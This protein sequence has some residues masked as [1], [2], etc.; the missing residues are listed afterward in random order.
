MVVRMTDNPGLVIEGYASVFG[1]RDL[2][3]DVVVRGA[4]TDALARQGAA[5]VRMLYQHDTAEPVGVWRMAFQDAHGLYVRGELFEDTPKGRLAGRLVRMGALDG[6]S[7]G[8]RT[9]SARRDETGRLRLLTDIDLWEV[10]LVTFPMLPSA[11]IVRADGVPLGSP[12]R[13]QP[14]QRAPY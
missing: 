9:R 12:R 4:F 14:A 8:F 3:D 1:Q 13:Q 5:G 10:S 11:R 2:N 6:L 7:I